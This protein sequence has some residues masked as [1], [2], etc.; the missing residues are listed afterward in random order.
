MPSIGRETRFFTL[1]RIYIENSVSS[2]EVR[3]FMR[4]SKLRDQCIYDQRDQYSDGRVAH[5]YEDETAW[6]EC[7]AWRR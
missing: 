4:R 3:A 7:A 6:D 2:P 5:E 1:D